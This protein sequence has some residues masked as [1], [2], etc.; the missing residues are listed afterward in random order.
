[1]QNRTRKPH[2]TPLHSLVKGFILTKATE[3]K[4]SHT[5]RYYEQIFRGFL[6]YADKQGWSDDARLLNEW[7]IREFLGYVAT[8][9]DRWGLLGNRSGSSL[10]QASQSTLHHY[11]RALRHLFGWAVQEGYLKGTPLA[12]IKI[13]RPRPKVIQPPTERQ[14]QALLKVCSLAG[15][16][17][18]S[19]YHDIM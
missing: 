13:I 4:S 17:W 9:K 15:I 10:K 12:N 6:W 3:G 11:F 16:C 7:H 8:Q 14:I 1:M 19:L 2:R 5:V 18:V